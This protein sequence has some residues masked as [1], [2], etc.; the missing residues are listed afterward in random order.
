MVAHSQRSY[1]SIFIRNTA[2]CTA[3][4]YTDP[5]HLALQSR[6]RQY[7]VQMSFCMETKF[8]QNKSRLNCSQ[9]RS[10]VVAYRLSSHSKIVNWTTV[11][12]NLARP[13]SPLL[14]I[15]YTQRV[16]GI[17]NKMYMRPSTRQTSDRF[18]LTSIWCT[19]QMH[20]IQQYQF[21]EKFLSFVM[22]E[23]R[24]SN[25]VRYIHYFALGAS[26]P[27]QSPAD[28]GK[29]LIHRSTHFHMSN[30]ES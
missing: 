11:S 20:C 25:F 12:S 8:E 19:A 18:K 26:S 5:L 7:S 27:L 2:L 16:H 28:S 30:A 22:V 24:K 13:K 29:W 6:S 1:T 15:I 21:L 4:V 3:F 10:V 14:K 17:R 9:W 23:H